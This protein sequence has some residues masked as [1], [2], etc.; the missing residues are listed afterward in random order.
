MKIA[1]PKELRDGETR[2]AMSPDM[3]KKL[4]AM[5]LEVMIET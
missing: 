5:G 4:V 3:I 2:V 1:I